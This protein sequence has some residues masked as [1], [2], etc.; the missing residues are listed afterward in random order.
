MT[1][2]EAADDDSLSLA[3]D[4][5]PTA[6]DIDECEDISLSSLYRL[7]T[8]DRACNEM[9][10][11]VKDMEAME[12]RL[13][14]LSQKYS[15]MSKKARNVLSDLDKVDSRQRKYNI[16][17]FGLEET[18]EDPESCEELVLDLASEYLR[19][20]LAKDDIVSAY[21]LKSSS[22]PR[23]L[24]VKLN[25]I[26]LKEKLLKSC[27]RL[28]GTGIGIREDYPWE[29][30]Q[31]RMLLG[32]K[33]VEERSAGRRASLEFNKLTVEGKVFVC[34]KQCE[35]VIE[36]EESE[37][38]EREGKRVLNKRDELEPVLGGLKCLSGDWLE[39]HSKLINDKLR[40][41]DGNHW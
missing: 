35:N 8:L 4:S 15:M 36:Y 22:A 3:V 39:R 30:R 6:A 9:R 32:K 10:Y 19:V 38:N 21:R 2:H 28:K 31:Q 16:V 26:E 12:C 41:L 17:V 33:L 14:Q 27:G 40:L 7:D 25:E 37:R 1:Q 20:P 29:V 24:L 23:P 13:S 5:D 18:E 11:I 34:D